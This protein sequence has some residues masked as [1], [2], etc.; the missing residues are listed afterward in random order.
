M[1]QIIIAVGTTSKQKIEY[2]E[3]LLV[4]IGLNAVILP[5][6]VSSDVSEQPLTKEET[7]MGSLNRAIRA[8]KENEGAN[9]G[10][11]IEVGY[12]K[13]KKDYE[14]FCCV[15]IIDKENKSISASS[16]FFKLPEHYQRKIKSGKYLG[17][18]LDGYIK[19][20]DKNVKRYIENMLRKRKPFIIEACRSALL[21]YFE[22]YDL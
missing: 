4:K 1:D 2:L 8:I 3:E 15:S 9:L 6:K 10:L 20:K 22:N 12:H 19:E 13:N 17:D 18:H 11:G 21:Q 7:T 16:H 14:I 5:T